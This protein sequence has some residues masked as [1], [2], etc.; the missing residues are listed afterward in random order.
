MAQANKENSVEKQN[1][2]VVDT[3]ELENVKKELENANLEKEALLK[4]I[5]ELKATVEKQNANA[6]K[7]GSYMVYAPVKD[8][9]GEVAGVQFAYGKANVQPGWV[10]EWFKEKGFKVEEV[11]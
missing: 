9:N 1:A 3:T 8:F 2:N 11:K 7:K 6:P 4:Q 5:E 10:L